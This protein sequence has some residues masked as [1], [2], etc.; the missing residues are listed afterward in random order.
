MRNLRTFVLVALIFFVGTLG[1]M[2]VDRQNAYMNRTTPKIAKTAE[3]AI[4][5]VEN[6]IEKYAFLR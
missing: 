1:V 2:H 3:N 4:E 5:T 6:T